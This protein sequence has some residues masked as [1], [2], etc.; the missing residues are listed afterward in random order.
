MTHDPVV[1]SRPGA[2]HG[3]FRAE[4][5]GL[6]WLAEAMPD[7]GARVVVPLEPCPDDASRIV[8]P[9]VREVPPTADAAW[10]L[11]GALAVTHAA[12]APFHGAPPPGTQGRQFIADLP[13]PTPPEQ[14][15]R[16]ASFYARY[17]IA[18]FLRAARD[19]GAVSA[20]QAERIEAVAAR[21]DSGRLAVPEQRPARLHGDLWSGNVLWSPEGAVLIDPS[22]HGGHPETDLAML[23]L[24]GAPDLDRVIA[25]YHERSPLTAG[26]R[27]RVALHQ[28]YPLLV[29][30]VL[31]GGGY[32]RQATDAARRY[33]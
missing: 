33:A 1:K 14:D 10:S 12:G 18:P 8:L 13:L 19:R 11:G 6:R 22:A 7:G 5:A 27:D 25:G 29:H 9:R 17:R 20:E 31:F 26:W 3:F 15:L 24:F 32:G 2:P 16:W 30:A 28:L 4:D 23:A 21:L